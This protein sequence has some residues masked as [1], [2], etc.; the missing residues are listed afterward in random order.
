[1]RITTNLNRLATSFA[2]IVSQHRSRF[3]L[4]W[5]WV[6][7]HITPV[8][9]EERCQMRL[10]LPTILAGA[11]LF[12][13]PGQAAD[14]E[15]HGF[16]LLNYSAR[17]TDDRPTQSDSDFLLGEER[18]RLDVSVWADGIEASARFKGDLFHDAVDG[19]TELDAREA[20]VDYTTGALDL[21][22][23]RQIATW[24]VGDLLFINDVFPKD[25]VSFFSG[26]PL[27]YLKIGVDGARIRYSGEAVNAEFIVIPFFTP[28]TLP[29]I[30]R[31]FLH[32]P[33][34]SLTNRSETE[35]TSTYDNTEL[36]LRLY[37]RAGTFDVAAYLYKGFWRS[38]GMRTN[39]PIV[40]SQVDLFYPRLNVY[41]ASAQGSALSG[42]LSLE[43][44]YYDSREDRDGDDPTVPNSQ[45]RFL[46][47]YQRQLQRDLTIGVQY[48]AE[49]MADHG[50]YKQSLPAGFPVQR[51]YRDTVTLH[52]EQLLKHQTVRLALFTF[53]SPADEDYLVQPKV[54]YRLSD[55]LAATLGVNLFGG[56]KDT[57]F[58]GQLDKNDN[59]YITVRFDF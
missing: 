40:P 55:K 21:R 48:Y 27:E 54:N 59:I 56:Q 44:G 18:L 36:A 26:R 28:D 57:T 31:F 16:L 42:I 39:D 2:R 32:D 58:L 23:G 47:G 25:Y 19:E 51:R 38:P 30:D 5:C 1:M 12:S 7:A 37:R 52:I 10:T 50:K 9:P 45:S 22:L 53:Y 6:T 11:L 49:V 35:P 15:T 3:N 14:L 29:T 34:A 24:G 8:L 13:M 17:T 43:A 41:G 33:L 4:C 20:Y 46:I